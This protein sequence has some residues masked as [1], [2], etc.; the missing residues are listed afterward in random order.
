MT[1]GAN[2]ARVALAVAAGLLCGV[3]GLR[4]AATLCRDAQ[5][6]HR[7]EAL[8]RHLALLLRGG[9]GSLPEVLRDAATSPGPPDETFRALAD[10]LVRNPLA[11]LSGLYAGLPVCQPEDSVLRRLMP[12]LGRG[13]AEQRC[14]AARQAADEIALLAASTRE[15]AEK[16]APMHRTLGWVFGACLTLMLL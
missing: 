5:R 4:R 11:D 12:R 13:S 8:L 16:D 1:G 2:A 9:G 7:L 10:G 3:M 6:L 15:K 14:Q